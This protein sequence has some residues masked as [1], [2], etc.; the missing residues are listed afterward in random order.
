MPGEATKLGPFTG[1][2]HNASGSGEF[3]QNEELYDLTN[4]EVDTDGSLVNRPQ[5][6]NFTITGI[7]PPSLGNGMTFIGVYLPSDG[8]KF[9]V[10]YLPAAGQ[11]RLINAATGALDGTLAATK[12]VCC[13]QYG[14]RL[15]VVATTD[16]PANG[17]Y[18]DVPTITTTSWT[19]TA[20]MPRGEAVAQYRERIWIACGLSATSNTSRFYFSA[21]AD[22]TSWTGTDFIDVAPGNGQKLVSLVRLGNDLVL[23]KEH[24]THKFTYTTD[25]RK[26][27]LNEI[28]ATIG[29][30]AINC[31]IVYNNNTIYTLH[32]NAVYELFQYTYTRISALINMEQ[33][34]DLDL[35]SKDQYGLTLHRDR[36]F[37]R[38]FKNLYVYN[39]R[40]KRWCRWVS[41]RKFSKVVVIPSATVGLDTAYTTSASQA[42]PAETYSFQD[43]RNVDYSGNLPTTA[44]VFQGMIQTKTYDFDLPQSYKVHFWWGVAVAT[45]GKTVAV[46]TIPNANRNMTYQQA[47]DLYVT[48]AAAITAKQSWASNTPVIITDT[49]YPSLGKYARKFLKVQKKVRF[50]QVFYTITFDIVTN[51][52]IADAALRLYDLTVLIKAK[53]TVVKQTS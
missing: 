36:L 16:S 25:P 34:T 40:V 28:D 14:N 50:R 27:E 48:W 15:Y 24:S 39:L 17:G 10:A 52:G 8:R 4:M 37:V 53:E 20:T 7:S 6:N 44:E 21:V 23:F 42:K 32:D 18:F 2:L 3:I 31:N 33:V 35:F 49:I 26:A 38:Y 30:P 9:I 46:L 43:I 13:I 19:S 12:S 1:G 29:V 11:V 45:S 51:G 5:I 47:K 22:P 41:D